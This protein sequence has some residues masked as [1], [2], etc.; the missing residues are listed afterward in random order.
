MPAVWLRPLLLL[1]LLWPV[2]GVAQDMAAYGHLAQRC[3]DSGSPAACR[4]ALEQSHR[5]K[6]WAE[7]RKRW[8]CY[9]A[10]LAAEAEMIAATLPIN[11]ERPSSDALQEMRLVCRL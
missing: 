4:A 11:R 10:V 3:G 9:T 2:A 5:L 7:A 1:P 8:R 6:N